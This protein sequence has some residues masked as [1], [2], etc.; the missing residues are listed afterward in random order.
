MD[1]K[2]LPVSLNLPAKYLSVQPF[3]LGK[4]VSYCFLLFSKL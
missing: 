4:G 3:G 1:V 2:C